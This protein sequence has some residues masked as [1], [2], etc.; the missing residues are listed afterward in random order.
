MVYNDFTVNELITDVLT[1]FLYLY[2][3]D[4]ENIRGRDMTRGI[5]LFN[6]IINEDN[7]PLLITNTDKLIDLPK[8]GNGTLINAREVL[9]VKLILD[10]KEG[11]VANLIKISEGQYLN[12]NRT[13]EKEGRPIYFRLIK[14]KINSGGEPGEGNTLWV[15]PTPDNHYQAYVDYREEQPILITHDN[16]LDKLS[17]PPVWIGYL[18]Y[19]LARKFKDYFPGAKWTDGMEAEYR[20]LYVMTQTPD[21]L[22]AIT[23]TDNALLDYGYW[24]DSY[25]WGYCGW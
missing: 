23:K 15:Y 7:I 17:L 14:N 12:M 25:R 24:R 18:R 13:I 16:V 9:G 4:F 6:E 1:D 10:V 19:A 21:S 22:D 20:R 8:G 11:L 2:G 5:K 3:T